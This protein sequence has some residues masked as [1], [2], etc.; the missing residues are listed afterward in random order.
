MTRERKLALWEQTRVEC[1]AKKLPFWMAVLRF[2]ELL[3]LEAKLMEQPA[4]RRNP[5]AR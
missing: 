4:W 3:E 5:G 2:A 1:E